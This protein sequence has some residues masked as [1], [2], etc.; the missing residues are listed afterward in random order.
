MTNLLQGYVENEVNL[1]KEGSCAG[2][3]D[4]YDFARNHHCA[5]GTFCNEEL[6]NG[7]KHVICSGTIVDCAFIESDMKIC[8]SVKIFTFQNFIMMGDI[9]SE[10]LVFSLTL[11]CLV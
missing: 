1:N 8:P 3:C 11:S 4:D 7:T 6:K 5:E 9:F 2:S 10:N